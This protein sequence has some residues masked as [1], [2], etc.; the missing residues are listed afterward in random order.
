MGIFHLH[1]R[2]T[3]AG[4]HTGWYIQDTWGRELG[5]VEWRAGHIVVVHNDGTLFRDCGISHGASF[6]AASDLVEYHQQ[7]DAAYEQ[8]EDAARDAEDGHGA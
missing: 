4:V 6:A 8:H 2:G 7:A 5:R 1:W 3:R